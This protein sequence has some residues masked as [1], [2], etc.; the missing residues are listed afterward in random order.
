VYSAID[1]PPWWLLKQILPLEMQAAVSYE[2][3]L[4][5]NWPAALYQRDVEQVVQEAYNTMLVKA[6]WRN[7]SLALGEAVSFSELRRTFQV[8]TVTY[9][10][11]LLPVWVGLGRRAL[12][13]AGAGE[14]PDRQRSFEQLAAPWAPE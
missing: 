5:G 4:L 1:F 12:S 10:L 9:Q 3:Q 8:T 13:P 2:P 14:W 11:V 7:R 6:I